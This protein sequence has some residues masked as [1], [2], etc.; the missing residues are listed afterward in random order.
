MSPSGERIC[1]FINFAD[2]VT[3]DSTIYGQMQFLTQGRKS[4]FWPGRQKIYLVDK[5]FLSLLIWLSKIWL[6][7][8]KT[9]NVFFALHTG[10]YN[11]EALKAKV[12]KDGN[13]LDRYIWTTNFNALIFLCTTQKFPFKRKRSIGMEYMQNIVLLWL[14]LS[15]SIGKRHPTLLQFAKMIDYE[16]GFL[17][18]F[19]NNDSYYFFRWRNRI[20]GLSRLDIAD[21]GPTVAGPL[22]TKPNLG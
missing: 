19:L 17:W 20:S 21:T 22:T 9:S 14:S 12:K 15:I 10:S 1:W 5:Y 6:H 2:K 11:E 7:R 16:I 8:W 13:Q 4:R 3:Q 18:A